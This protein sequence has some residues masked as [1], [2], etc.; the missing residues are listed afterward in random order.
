[1]QSKFLVGASLFILSSFGAMA[2]TAATSPAPPPPVVAVAPPSPA[3]A[4]FPGANW[5]YAY[6]SINQP[7]M[8]TFDRSGALYLPYLSY[9]PWQGQN[10]ALLVNYA[11][12][13]YQ[14]AKN[15]TLNA[16]AYNAAVTAL[17]NGYFITNDH[18]TL[19]NAVN[20]TAGN[21]QNMLLP[22]LFGTTSPTSLATIPGSDTV[23]P[24]TNPPPTNFA[25]DADNLMGT[26]GFNPSSAPNMNNLII[27]LTGLS[28]PIPALSLSTTQS[29]RASQLQNALVQEYILQS[30]QLAATQSVALSNFNYLA[31]ERQIIPGLGQ[32]S[33]MTTL[34]TDGTQQPVND[35]SQLQLQAFL[36]NRRVGNSSWYTAI[37]SAP[38]IGVQRETVFVLAEMQKQLLQLQMVNERMLATLSVMQTQMAQFGKASLQANQQAAS[39]AAQQVASN[40]TTSQ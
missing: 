24:N 39:Q 37:E 16:G 28:Q 38:A 4:I 20:A 5:P 22:N 10:T 13:F 35:A 21:V 6:P 33:G 15:N 25:F 36:I 23:M 30:R 18:I 40:N 2:Q 27:F 9:V 7:S 1:M 17:A 29:V 19:Q 32:K 11:D 14:L 8:P 12:F 3:G 34:P 31:N 26:L